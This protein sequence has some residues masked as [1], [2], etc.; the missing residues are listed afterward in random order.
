MACKIVK[1]N[2]CRAFGAMIV[3]LS[4]ITCFSGLGAAASAQEPGLESREIKASIKNFRKQADKE[5][6]SGQYQKAAALSAQLLPL[7]AMKNGSQSKDY[8]NAL[9]VHSVD[10]MQVGR[11]KEAEKIVREA[12]RLQE[13]IFGVGSEESLTA[14]NNLAA[15][16]FGQGRYKEAEPI[17]RKVLASR[18]QMLGSKHQDTASSLSNLALNLM[19][20][21]RHDEAEP[22]NRLA[23]E[24][25]TKVLGKGHSDTLDSLNNLAG[26]L[27][28]QERY[29]DAEPLFRQALS[30]R[31][32]TLGKKHP[33]TLIS[34]D[35]LATILGK[36][37]RAKE[38]EPLH[39]RAYAMNIE[40]SGDKHPD[41]LVSMG[42]L[43]SN[44]SK[45]HRYKEAEALQ[46][47]AIEYMT[48][49]L[50]EAHPTTLTAMG[51]MGFTLNHM[52]NDEEAE[53]IYRQILALKTKS[54]GENHPDTLSSYGNLA[55]NLIEQVDRADLAIVP[56]RAVL[57]G[58]LSRWNMRG[59]D[60]R[61]EAQYQREIKS[62]KHYFTLFA[63][64]GWIAA[65]EN[66][67]Q[68]EPLREE[69]YSVLQKA[70]VG[71][72]SRAVAQNAARRA[73]ENQAAGLGE[74]LRQRQSLANEW[75]STDT[76]I[77]RQLIAS[78]RRK[79]RKLENLRQ[80]HIAL[81]Q[82]IEAIDDHVRE[83]FPQ[84]FSMVR[85]EPL[86]I[87]ETQA[88]L[89]PDEAF[90]MVVPA[91]LGTHVI[92]ISDDGI[93][94][95]RS[96]WK[97][98]T[99]NAVVKRLLWDVGATVDVSQV[100]AAEWA[101]E[102]EGVYP[103]D[104]GTA[105]ALYNQIIAPVADRLKGKRH[106]FI[107][108]TGSL[109]SL[110]FGILVAEK[111]EGADGNPASL[112]A[113]RWFADLHALVQ[114]PSLQS[115]QFLRRA[116][117]ADKNKQDSKRFIGFGDPVLL[118]QS[119]IRGA[120]GT[121]AKHD[122]LAQSDDGTAV[123]AFRDSRTR[124]GAGIADI[125]ALRKM[126]RLPGTAQELEAMRIALNA[127]QAS[128]FTAA[129]ASESNVRNADLSG[130]N[131]VALATHGLLAGEIHGAAEPGLVFTPPTEASEND[132]GLLTASEITGLKLN[133]EWVIMSACNT[134]AGDG[135]EG[136]PGLSGLARSFF[137]AGARNLLASHWPVRDDVAARIT[138]RTIEIK[139]D[140]PQLSRAEAFQRAMQE[141]R[142]DPSADSDNDTW[143]H[144][145]AW[146]P[147]ALIGDGAQ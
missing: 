25:R 59:N 86:T 73:A 38:A 42:M 32:K 110:P 7:I 107:A 5:R 96:D 129:R 80:K 138:V 74:L 3:A 23:F 12:L 39:R 101:E 79:D 22:L 85:P 83:A 84:Y 77:N 68:R 2:D 16:M 113:T 143:A 99:I 142:N 48:E 13:E 130:V 132:D 112:R 90:L 47:R 104:R 60:A 14:Y 147:F 33:G 63:D 114:I 97:R 27:Q 109:S 126:A 106:V 139:R 31:T 94:W 54:R 123:S 40:I 146:A 35:N 124:S 64:A 1:R 141:I 55:Y 131:I 4:L 17:Y 134:A 20:Q 111:P 11:N 30:I 145:N 26:N 50:G 43:A 62:K 117:P 36:L 102:G 76:R 51:N 53:K 140:N 29:A 95:A 46:R 52:G 120:G 71:P 135:S 127:P 100:Q 88:M 133:A 118:G 57:N 24:I 6:R 87:A 45:Q 108:T 41:T 78:E 19:M 21:G 125:T 115:L 9:M 116:S 18:Q 44:L 56:A 105:F 81:V 91:A 92:A 137:Y 66:P 122:N 82:K 8:A 136:A 72:A 75:Q 10:L 49:V 121:R 128:I 67:S 65:G 89:G 58:W 34:L 15:N 37:G 98:G 93:Q 69:V 28:L 119:N 61:A 70:V 144:P 103:Y